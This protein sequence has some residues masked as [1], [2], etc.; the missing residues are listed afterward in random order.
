M[1]DEGNRQ[2][3]IDSMYELLAL[4]K[5]QLEQL[6][7]HTAKQNVIAHLNAELKRANSNRFGDVQTNDNTTRT[8]TAIEA[9]LD[10]THKEAQNLRSRLYENRRQILSAHALR[11]SKIRCP[12]AAYMIIR[13]MEDNPEMSGYAAQEYFEKRMEQFKTC[14]AS[15]ADCLTVLNALN[16]SKTETDEIEK[17]ILINAAADG[18][19]TEM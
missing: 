5:E 1:A 8:I 6:D 19:K 4:Y 12:F 7:Q 16:K 2:A 13:I 11:G 17:Q 3:W 10:S 9:Q 14:G 15:D 18:Q